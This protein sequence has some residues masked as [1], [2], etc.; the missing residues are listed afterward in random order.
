HVAA[1]AAEVLGREVGMLDAFASIGGTS[2]SA[3]R[4]ASILGHRLGRPV[5][6]QILLAAK[7]LRAACVELA[8]PA[9]VEAPLARDAIL[10]PA[11]APR[12]AQARAPLARV[13]LTGATGFYGT[14]VLA[15][16]LR[17]TDARVT[18]LV[19]APSREA[20]RG[21]VLESLERRQCLVDTS[22]ID[23]VLG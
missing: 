19:R 20:A 8:E 6:A 3:V 22:R 4:A 9:R 23:V 7:S 1:V 15:D 17:E 2:L 13:L 16:L 12:G 5:R 18:C 21:R 10:D 11:I 14:F